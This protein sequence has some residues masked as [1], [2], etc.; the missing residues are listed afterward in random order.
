MAS[1]ILSES[2]P[3]SRRPEN[4][5]PLQ[6]VKVLDFM[7]VLAGPGI[8]RV[9]ADYGATVI[10]IESVNRTDPTRTVGPFQD[11]RSGA[12]R[13]GLWA[14]NNAGKYGI[15]LDLSTDGAREIVRDLVLWADV[16]C[17]A[18]SPKAMRAWSFDYESLRKVKP[19]L[20]MLST[21]LMGQSG[22]LAQFAGFGNLAAAISG[23]TNLAGWPGRQPAGPFGAN[24]DY[25]AP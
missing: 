2:E 24:T 18:F 10:R 4:H 14:N 11:G 5:L 9:L 8:T 6:N 1:T 23:F 19:D 3:I 22:P 16:V 12:E 13:S 20:I 21:C 25:I 17:E 15:T 7:W